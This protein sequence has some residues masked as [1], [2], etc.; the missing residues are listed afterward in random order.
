[1]SNIIFQ[2]KYLSVLRS[3]IRLEATEQL[4][5]TT[6]QGRIAQSTAAMSFD[7]L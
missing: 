7:E 2:S 3:I 4:L 6:F 1:M 5:K